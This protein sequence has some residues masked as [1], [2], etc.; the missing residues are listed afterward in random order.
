MARPPI[1]A[2]RKLVTGTLR[3]ARRRASSAPAALTRTPTAPS[4]LDSDAK[5][6]WNRFGSA[7]V[8][9]GSLTAADL[10]LLELLSR[11][12]ASCMTLERLLASEGYVISS[13]GATKGHPA[14]AALAGARLM[15]HRLMTDLGLSAVG[16]QRIDVAAPAENA[17]ERK[18]H[19]IEAKYFTN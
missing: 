7:A 2:N 10:G 4:A 12:W 14:T 16:R 17:E 3:G 8:K 5:E 15:A 18:Q 11:T 13:R 1:S 19:R 6:A 9:V